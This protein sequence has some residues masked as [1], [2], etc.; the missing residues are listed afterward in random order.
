MATQY[1]CNN[2]RRRA[3]VRDTRQSNGRP[4]LNGIDY[5]EVLPDRKTLLIY[6][7]HPLAEL[8]QDNVFNAESITVTGGTRIQNIQVESVSAFANVLLVQVNRVG[9]FSVYTL[10]L[11]KSS[12]NASPPKGIDP[13]LA[14]IEFYF[15]VEEF[16][17]FD[18]ATPEPLPESAPAP[19]VIDYLAKDYA[20]FRRL[21]LDRLAVTIPE[22]QERSPAD[23][24]IVLV[25]L[26]AYAA[27]HLSY[28]QDAVA[29]EAYLG[30]ARKRVSVRR[31]VRLLDYLMHDGCNARAWIVVQLKEA[32]NELQQ[33]KVDG[34]K[35]L[36][37][38]PAKN[39]SGVQFFTRTILGS[40]SLPA[41]KVEASL[42]A[43]AQV[44]ETLH[45]ITLYYAFNEINFYTWGNE[46]C[47]LPKGSTCATLQ[48]E[49]GRLQK[50]LVPGSVLVFEEVLGS[51][52]GNSQDAD[53]SHRHVV[54]LTQVTGSIDPL[55]RNQRRIQIV[56]VEWSAADALPFDL[57]I[58]NIDA[59]GRPLH[60]ITVARGNVV[61][62]DAGR[63]LKAEALNQAPGWNQSRPRPRLQ[64]RNLTYQGYVYVR[65]RQNPW[66]V[67]D[68]QGAASAAMQWQ[69]RDARPA[70]A[71]WE[72]QLP[73]EDG[74]PVPQWQPQRD[75]LISDR[76]A[77]D[78][79]VETEDDG[80]AYL[81]F[82]EGELGK[83]PDSEAP[84][85]AVYRVGNGTQGNVGAG[86]IANVF[87]Q[88]HNLEEE[89]RSHLGDI[90]QAIGQIYNPLAAEGGT[91]P[92][93][94][95]QV[96]LYAPQAF[97]EQRRT[98]TAADYAAMA[99]H[100][101]GVQKALATRRWTGSWHT[102]FI[103]VDREAGRPVDEAFKQ[104]LRQFLEE[105]R[106]AGHDI[107]IDAPRYVPLDIALTIQVKPD[108]FR[109][110][111]KKALLDT[112]SSR[113]LPTG[114]LGFFNV[115]RFTFGQPVYLSQ[116]IA[117]AMQVEGVQF[118]SVRRFQRWGEAANQELEL[119]Q[120]GFDRLEIA[121]L[122]NDPSTPENGRLEIQ[123]E[124]GL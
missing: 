118:A 114:Q 74:V 25:E 93:P 37:A 72:G 71:L 28:Y 97:R 85:F 111:V 60:N 29:T 87:I 107:E 56:E 79:V 62:A 6:L 58:S 92:E 95:D 18:C 63:T 40:G 38:D 102:I 109:S 31:H 101:P 20:S 100:Y 24:G 19:P 34:M 53:L 27:D 14:Q 45:D 77:R 70:I 59:Q 52:T 103:T 78:F 1:R 7:I 32:L 35:L 50:L 122:D 46:Q 82:G 86:A 26:M 51:A 108:Y 13:Q 10:R 99:Q 69:L 44:F 116:V 112:F 4:L 104:G 11:V 119:G 94:I 64:E 121:R 16:S 90:Q 55:P 110:A 49:D 41:D 115:D 81:R 48:D 57:W 42:N 76:F 83:Q 80:R 43:G 117:Q 5:L 68:P 12:N 120:I 105:F 65:Q 98:V 73:G 75:L 96:R 39:R 15:W 33:D 88:P 36:G 113:I 84:L 67:F 17:E 2:E 30:T 89:M 47:R 106:L 21:M 22:W 124:G 8:E 54:R 91:E 66:V 9:D 3:D 123:L 61:L 23:L